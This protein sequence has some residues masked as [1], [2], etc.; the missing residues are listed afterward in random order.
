MHISAQNTALPCFLF[1]ACLASACLA[2]QRPRVIAAGT[3]LGSTPVVDGNHLEFHSSSQATAAAARRPGSPS[4][5]RL[6]L[7]YAVDVR[8][9]VHVVD[10]EPTVVALWCPSV[11]SIEI[12]VSDDRVLRSWG[13]EFVLVAAP[14]WGC[15]EGHARR[16]VTDLQW[17][18]ARRARAS[19]SRA[20]LDDLFANA[21][22][23]VVVEQP[24]QQ[25]QQRPSRSA[26]G[27]AEV[28]VVGLANQTCASA[29][30]GNATAAGAEQLCSLCRAGDAGLATVAECRGCWASTTLVRAEFNIDGLVFAK[31]MS[32]VAVQTSTE[33]V[34]GEAVVSAMAPGAL[35]ASVEL[36]TATYSDS[37]SIGLLAHVKLTLV[38]STTAVVSLQSE[39]AARLSMSHSGVVDVS[40]GMAQGDANATANATVR[41][42]SGRS[43]GAAAANAD[44]RASVGLQLLYSLRF[45]DYGEVDVWALPTLSARARY[46]PAGMGPSA[47]QDLRPQGAHHGRCDSRHLLEFTSDYAVAAG[48]AVETPKGL[49]GQASYDVAAGALASGCPHSAAEAAEAVLRF[50]T[51]VVGVAAGVG[52]RALAS[53]L[54]HEMAHAAGA[55]S[56]E[57]AVQLREG[58]KVLAAVVV[59][60]EARAVAERLRAQ[61][62]QAGSALWREPIMA[63]LRQ[64]F[65]S[66]QTHGGSGQSTEGSRTTGS[67]ASSGSVLCASAAM[68]AAA[69]AVVASC[70]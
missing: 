28:A 52:E 11:D 45:E 39:G 26:N 42:G 61:A 12:E 13:D 35:E 66:A 1:L 17:T 4:R 15:V 63:R 21:S 53:G 58:A 7:D 59:G 16:R 5:P 40:V 51:S 32:S 36:G 2:Q 64:S 41:A 62:E 10:T 65:Q 19:T 56:T 60:R 9:D 33:Y 20:S 43:D 31:K 68:V 8:P 47:A 22:I 49:S 6:S 25:Q 50:S 67:A 54:A 57:V 24:Q 48:G 46:S 23:R 18:S 38:T 70:H 34:I 55:N 3:L 44:A 69:L 29:C 37:V 14:E 30:G 27:S